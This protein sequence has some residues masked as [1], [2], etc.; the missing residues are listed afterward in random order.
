MKTRH[1]IQGTILFT[2][3]VALSS[4]SSD[5]SVSSGGNVSFTVKTVSYG[6]DRA[7]KNIVAIWVEDKDGNFIKTRLLLAD[8]RKQWLITWNEKSKGSTVDAVT[9]ATL[10]DHQSHNIEWD[11][12]DES[13]ALVEDGDYKIVVE[14]TEE[15]AQGPMTSVTFTK[16]PEPQVISPDNETNF[17]DL[18]LEYTVDATDVANA[19]TGSRELSIYPNPFDDL[20]TIRFTT[21]GKSPVSF[22]IFDSEGA[23]LKDMKFIPGSIGEH[24]LQ[25]DGTDQAGNPLPAGVYIL[26]VHSANRTLSGL[27]IKR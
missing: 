7:P 24:S 14:F 23:L 25:W 17:I 1:F 21:T 16:G 2:I 8:R 9:G 11:C 6:G 27:V 4:F 13:G 20:A 15:H 12:T 5:H 19:H 3:L 10:N 18:K 26:Q 22:K